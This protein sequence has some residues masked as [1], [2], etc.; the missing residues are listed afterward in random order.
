MRKARRDWGKRQV[1]MR[2]TPERLIFLDETDTDTNMTRS[3]GRC[4]KGR[5]LK[6]SAPFRRWGNQTLIAGLST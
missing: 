1:I 4:P 2:A 3:H 5:R 6:G